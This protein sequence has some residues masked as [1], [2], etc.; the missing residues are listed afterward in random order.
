MTTPAPTTADL[1]AA[2]PPTRALDALA[3]L[4]AKRDELGP[5]FAA[6]AY[7]ALGLFGRQA[8]DVLTWLLDRA[9]EQIGAGA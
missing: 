9:D 5:G 8:P 1:L 6:Y 7:M 2:L 3:R 4:E